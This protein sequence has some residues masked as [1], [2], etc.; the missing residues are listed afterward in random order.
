MTL[1]I[2]I[3]YLA[4]NALFFVFLSVLV[5]RARLKNQVP[6]GDGGNKEVLKAIRIHG[7]AAEYLP[8]TLLLLL[9]LE[10]NQAPAGLLHGLGIAVTAGRVAHAWGI[11]RTIGPSVGR[12]IGTNLTFLSIIV[13]AVYGL[14]LYFGN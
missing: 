6:L 13:G 5:I 14:V 8:I 2:T 10:S 9:L 12:F 11:S 4:I 1:P 7:N 3:F